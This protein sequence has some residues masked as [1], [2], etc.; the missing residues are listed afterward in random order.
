MHGNGHWSRQDWERARR[1][2]AAVWDA[3]FRRYQLP[4]FVWVKELLRDEEAAFDV[5]QETFARAVRHLGQLRDPGRVGPWLFGI[6]RQ[7]CAD[8]FRRLRR[9]PPPW[10]A[11]D[12]AA[13][14][15]A[16]DPPDPA[17][18]PDEWLIRREDEARFLA[19]LDGL[20]EAQRAVAVLYLLEEFRLEDI[21][22]VLGVPLGTVKSRLHHARRRLREALQEPAEFPHLLR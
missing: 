16:A 9:Q 4:L 17:P 15:G 14:P 6:A 13:D 12:S 5:V 21:G 3:L 2:D 20:P 19:A 8:H 10:E 1:G 22:R 11:G 18:A 7:R